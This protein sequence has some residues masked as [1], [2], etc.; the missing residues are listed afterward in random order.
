MP[1]YRQVPSRLPR[2]RDL[3][4]RPLSAMSVSVVASPRFEPANLS[5]TESGEER[6][7]LHKNHEGRAQAVAQCVVMERPL[8]AQSGHWPKHRHHVVGRFLMAVKAAQRLTRQSQESECSNRRGRHGHA[9]VKTDSRSSCGR[10]IGR[11]EAGELL[12]RPVRPR[13]ACPR[14]PPA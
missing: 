9:R 13:P 5:R 14:P 7:A 8:M 1:I 10:G 3:A 4:K 12:H 11:S 6:L 2:R